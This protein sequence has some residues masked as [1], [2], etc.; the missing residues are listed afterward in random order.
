MKISSDGEKVEQVQF[1]YIEGVKWYNRKDFGRFKIK[2][3]LHLLYDLSVSR[4]GIYS[5]FM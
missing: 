5:R 4:L 2:L 1:S 3:S